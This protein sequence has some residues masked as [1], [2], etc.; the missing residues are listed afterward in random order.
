MQKVINI[1]IL[2]NIKSTVFKHK[3]GLCEGNAELGAII[4]FA[5]LSK[6]GYTLLHINLKAL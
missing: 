1:G 4:F 5:T 3:L 2:N 6:Q